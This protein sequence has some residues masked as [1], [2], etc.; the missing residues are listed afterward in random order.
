MINSLHSCSPSITWMPK[1][2][3]GT[4]CTIIR[5]TSNNNLRETCGMTIAKT[6]ENLQCFAGRAQINSCLK[7][8]DNIVMLQ[9][10]KSLDRPIWALKCDVPIDPSNILSINTM[11]TDVNHGLFNP[12]F[13]VLSNG[14]VSDVRDI[15]I[16][17]IVLT[18]AEGSFDQSQRYSG[19][20]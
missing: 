16:N 14:N 3:L 11:Q 19:I 6:I 10:M 15:G 8:L 17:V 18:I 12:R 4:R 2:A 20:L 1:G 13:V 9:L 7:H 5:I